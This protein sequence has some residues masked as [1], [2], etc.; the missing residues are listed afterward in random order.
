MLIVLLKVIFKSNYET[1]EKFKH[2]FLERKR[3]TFSV[4]L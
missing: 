1:K 2:I 4:V 3:I